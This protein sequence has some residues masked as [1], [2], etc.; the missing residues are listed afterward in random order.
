M[1]IDLTKN[2]YIKKLNRI[3]KN[4]QIIQKKQGRAEE[5]I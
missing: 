2:K 4:I 3:L 1:Q 5:Q